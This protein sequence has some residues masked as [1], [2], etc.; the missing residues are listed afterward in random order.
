MLSSLRALQKTKVG[1]AIVAIFFILILI[2]FASTGVTNFGSGNLGFGM[3]RSTLAKVGSE[4]VTEQE[5]S[6][7]MQRRLQQIRLQKPEA[8]YS[9]IIGDLDTLLDELINEK[10]ILAFSQKFHFPLSKRLVDAEIAQLPQ[11]KGPGGQFSQ[12]AY[13]AF[14]A[15]QRLTDDQIREVLTSGLLERY[16]LTPV[17]AN[18]RISAGMA[19]PFAAMM[20]RIAGGTGCGHTARG[21]PRWSEPDRCRA[22]AILF[23]Q[24]RPLHGSGAARIANRPHRAGTGR[25]RDRLRPG[26]HQLLQHAQG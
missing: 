3:T 9:S 21:V 24:S 18:A 26:N 20:L 12:Q 2:G 10:A 5:T 22:A 8:D 1:T 23:G 19:T 6:D 7:A 16:V 25:G 14:L 15:Q 11:T 13:Q 17:A 4:E